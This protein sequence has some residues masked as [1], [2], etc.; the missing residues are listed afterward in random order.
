[1]K[2]RWYAEGDQH[3][4]E[5][6]ASEL[7]P[8]SDQRLRYRF[9]EGTPFAGVSITNSDTILEV[10]P[11]ERIIASSRMAFGDNCISVALIT[12]ELQPEDQG[13]QLKLTFQGAFLPGADGPQIRE[14]GWKTC[15]D[16]LEQQFQ[17]KVAPIA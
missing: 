10:V 11:E 17:S 5:E 2:R 16:R 8:G 1:M 6:F 15:F 14:M 9:R 3:E 12:T 13:T 4:V 7:R